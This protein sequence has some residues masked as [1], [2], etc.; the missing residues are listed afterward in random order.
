MRPDAVIFGRGAARIG[1][2]VNFAVPGHTSAVL[3][4]NLDLAGISVSAGSACSSGKIGT[5]HVLR[6][7]GVANALSGAALRVS[8]GWS[9]RAEDVE[10]FLD[11]LE[12]AL[13]RRHGV[14]AA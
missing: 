9:S 11:G 6:A 1:N 3:M 14:R 7:M 5:S 12:R 8:L 4:M 2:V 13:A 10:V